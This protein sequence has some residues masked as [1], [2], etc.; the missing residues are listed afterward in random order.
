ML[1]AL[2]RYWSGVQG[3]CVVETNLGLEGCNNLSACNTQRADHGANKI[4]SR[5]A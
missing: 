3:V 1:S 4:G 2:V 5:G